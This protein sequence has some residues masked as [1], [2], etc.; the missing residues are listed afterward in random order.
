[1]SFALSRLAAA[2]LL[3]AAPLL[4]A[5][6]APDAGDLLREVPRAQPATPAA[7]QAQPAADAVTPAGGPRVTVRSFVLQGVTLLPEADLQARLAPLVGQAAGLADLQRAAD[8][9]AD[10]YAE[11]GYLA[12]AYLPEQSI[13]DGRITIAVLEGRL[14]DLRVELQPP[15]LR[16]TEARARRMLLARQQLGEPVR[17]PDIQRAVTLLNELPGVSVRSMLEPGQRPG[18][19]QLVVAVQDEPLVSGHVLLDNAGSKATG[20]WR[21]SGG[22]AFDSPARLGDQARLF[23][24]KSRDAA[25]LSGRYAL[26]LGADGLRGAVQVSRLDYDYDLGGSRYDGGATVLGAE[27]GYPLVRRSGFRLQA[28]AAHDRK[29]FDNAVA[30]LSLNDKT[31]QLTTLGLNGELGDAHFGGGVTQFG[32]E[33]A[34]GRL[35]LS[36]NAADL[37]ADQAGPQRHGSFR[38]LGWS[39][40][41]VQRLSAADTLTLTL[42]GQRASRNLD[43]AE[44]MGVTGSQAVRAYAGAEPSGD[45]AQLLT[46]EW[47]HRWNEQLTLAAYHERARVRRDHQ[48]HVGTL[49]P[50][51]YTLSGSGLGLS[52]G[53]A[54]QLLV[55]AAVAWRHGDNPARDAAT[56]ADADG[57]Q[58]DPRAHL[59]LLRVF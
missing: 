59:S 6:S 36:R 11:R 47:R 50:N 18:E 13:T 34:A 19:T 10:L 12:R 29:A 26:P 30:G 53:R 5:Q 22:V 17:A 3:L 31:I 56:G 49:P 7:P 16:L 40:A 33:L 39:L 4:H 14:A 48:A 28:S 9:V 24:S 20:E 42:A 41:R 45:D 35:D 43:S 38:K 52:W 2:A 8:A 23:A 44:K 54:D 46:L 51:R 37:A 58:R 15:G 55:R 25:Y 1:M 57:S 21:L 32:L 27:L